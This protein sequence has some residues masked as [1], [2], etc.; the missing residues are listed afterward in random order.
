MY[1]N[2]KKKEQPSPAETSRIILTNKKSQQITEKIRYKQYK[3]IF[4][5][6]SPLSGKIQYTTIDFHKTDKKMIDIIYPLIQE[7]ADSNLE[8][9]FS[10]FCQALDALIKVLTPQEKWYLIFTYKNEDIS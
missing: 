2:K 5:S 3:K 7:L 6:L 4:E 10:Q 8:L 1:E 9:S